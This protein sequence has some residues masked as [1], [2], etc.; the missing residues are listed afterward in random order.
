MPLAPS[1]RLFLSAIICTHNPKLPVLERTVAALRAQDYP[2]SG[3]E[4]FIIE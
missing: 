4:F 2:V 3:F 1:N